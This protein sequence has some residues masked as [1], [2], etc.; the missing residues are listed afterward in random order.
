[1]RLLQTSDRLSRW[2]GARAGCQPGVVSWYEGFARR[3]DEWAAHMTADVPF[4]VELA[5]AADGPLVELAVGT[6]RVAVP[7]ARATGRPVLGIDSSPAMLAQAAARAEHAG[8]R[9]DLRLGDMR[10]LTVDEPA[11]LIYCPFRSL[12][13]LPTWADRRRTFHRVAAALRPAAGSPGT[14]SPSTT[15][16][17]P[18][19]PAPA[20]TGRC[21]TL[22]A[23]PS[24]TTA[25]TPR[26]TT[27][28]PAASGGAKNEWLGLIGQPLTDNSTE[29]VFITHRPPPP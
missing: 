3:Y 5:Q 10:E 29:Y 25:S 24:P 26:A 14:P 16:S 12:L 9:L 1:L 22:C 19:S 13:H 28:R 18:V 8:V 11:A 17:P 7:V 4:Y 2:S 23:T 21:P 15:T 6:G 27:V 20:P